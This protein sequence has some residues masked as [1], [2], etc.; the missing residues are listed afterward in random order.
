MGL[1]QRGNNWYI[2]YYA[3]GIRMRE[4]VGSSRQLA[5]IVLKKRTVEIAENRFLDI[6]KEQKIKFDE[7]AEEYLEV[8]LKH[9]SRSWKKADL[10]NI[11]RLKAFFG[12]RYLHEITPLLIERFK[13]DTS[14]VVSPS[15]TNRALTRLKAIFNKAIVWKKFNGDN[16]VKGIKFFKENNIRLR[17]LEKEEI[18][19]L[20]SNSNDYLRPIVIVALNTGMR[21]GEIYNLKWHDIDFKRS[22]IYLLQTKN[23]EKREIPMNETIKA[24]LIKVRKDPNSPYVFHNDDGRPFYN[25][26]KSFFTAC[27]KSG[28]INFRFHDLRHT[29]AS[30]LVMSG[31]DL[32]TVRE[33]LGHKSLEMTLRYS[34]LS[35]DHKKRA[36]DILASQMVPNWSQ[37]LQKTLPAEIDKDITILDTNTYDI[38]AH[39]ST[40]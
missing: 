10:H 29:F 34:H 20:L 11:K 28:I 33:L 16:P 12:S 14:K 31:V 7:F 17:F 32:N 30:Q 1:R 6:K 3:N 9:N 4:R 27:K 18:A 15:S 26:R 23:G 19:R 24:E 2:D 22:I 39:S 25:L 37:G 40:G 21:R 8:Y 5:E 36:V 38:C 35:L 13:N